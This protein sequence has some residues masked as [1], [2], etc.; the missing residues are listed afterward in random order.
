MDKIA[1]GQKI[2]ELR[3]AKGFSQAKLAELVDLHEKHIS[4]IESGRYLPNFDNLVK[5]LTVLEYDITK[6]A[7]SNKFE[8]AENPDRAKLH[9]IINNANDT[10]LKFYLGL[11]E[12]VQKGLKLFSNSD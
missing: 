10:E 4:R 6:I 1:I 3:K 7:D 11:M 9:K 8:L 2:Q 12:Q 5:I